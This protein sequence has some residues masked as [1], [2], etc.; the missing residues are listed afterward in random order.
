MQSQLINLKKEIEKTFEVTTKITETNTIILNVDKIFT[1]NETMI[2]E[3]SNENENEVFLRHLYFDN[4]I[5]NDELEKQT[6]KLS[7]IIIENDFLIEDIISFI[8]NYITSQLKEKEFAKDGKME[9]R[10]TILKQISRLKNLEI[11]ELQDKLNEY[12]KEIK[13]TLLKE[14]EIKGFRIGDSIMIKKD[15]KI[16][17]CLTKNK[18]YYISSMEVIFNKKSFDYKPYINFVVGRI[19]S[20]GYSKNDRIISSDNFDKS[21][22]I[23]LFMKIKTEPKKE[24]VR[25]SSNIYNNITT[26]VLDEPEMFPNIKN[27]EFY[28]IK[29][30][31]YCSAFFNNIIDVIKRKII[32]NNETNQKIFDNEFFVIIYKEKTYV[33]FMVDCEKKFIV[34]EKNLNKLINLIEEKSKYV[35]EVEDEFQVKNNSGW[36]EKWVSKNASV[37]S[38][39]LL[40]QYKKEIR[41]YKI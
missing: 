12:N 17:T 18:K 25:K 16:Y 33:Y 14:A 2:I 30:L 6:I 3:F 24:F 11:K 39:S 23:D 20:D 13:D 41:D 29:E 15:N 10:I 7:K 28:K 8:K 36:L 27:G 32:T 19:N 5:V 1:K 35:F 37:F 31:N 40:N 4:G 26:Y 9:N 21:N 38:E 34:S 22:Q